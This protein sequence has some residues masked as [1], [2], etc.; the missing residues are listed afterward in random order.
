MR[1]VALHAR[2][3]GVPAALAGT[4]A[5]VAVILAFDG[6]LVEHGGLAGRAPALTVAALAALLAA[7]LPGAGLAGADDALERSTPVS[8]AR[9]RAAHLV[10]VGAVTAA[11]STVGGTTSAV[12]DG[13]ALLLRDTA[14]LLGLTALSAVVLGARTAWA[15][16]TTYLL[17]TLLLG[18]AGGRGSAVWMWAFEAV[19]SRSAAITSA[20]LFLVGCVAY[21]VR[22]ARPVPVETS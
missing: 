9:V 16:V 22:G 20:V 4:L 5:V 12:L 6:W 8:W 2:A 14:G 21:A 17:L 3:R 7:V 10:G 19:D 18:T 13:P 11:V 15:P 1:L